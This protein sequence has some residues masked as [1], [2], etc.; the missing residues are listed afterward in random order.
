MRVGRL[1]LVE[2][3]GAGFSPPVRAK[4]ENA[5]TEIVRALVWA[6]AIWL[7]SFAAHG[8]RFPADERNRAGFQGKL[9]CRRLMTL[10]DEKEKRKKEERKE[11]LD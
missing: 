2:L 8:K 3:V 11:K 4:P 10:V 6:A 1:S 9:L 7:A 5:A